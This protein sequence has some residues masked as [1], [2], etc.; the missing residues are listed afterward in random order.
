MKK[1]EIDR[2]EVQKYM[3]LPY[4]IMVQEQSED[5]HYFFGR[6]LELEGCMSHGKTIEELRTNIHEAME[7]YI[8]SCLMDED[9]IP[10]P[11]AETEYSGRFNLRIPKSLHERLAIEAKREGVSLNQY[12]LYK[13]AL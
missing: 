6:V 7:S 8:E 4:T 3:E 1:N 12:A 13:L 9:P 5:G 11:V 2:S 10:V